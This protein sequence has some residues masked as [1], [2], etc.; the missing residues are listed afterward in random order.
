MTRIRFAVVGA[1]AALVAAAGWFGWR[2]WRGRKLAAVVRAS[3]PTIPDL[4]AWPPAY[5][6]LLREATA[7]ARQGL[8]P[9][10]ALGEI[11]RLYHANGC[12]RQAERAERGLHTIDPDN[13]KWTYLLADTCDMRG[14]AS[15]ERQY[16]VAALQAAPYY[17]PIRLRIANL[18]FNQGDDTDAAIHY[19]WLLTMV[20][21]DPAAHLGL[22]RIALQNGNRRRAI[23]E[24]NAITRDHPTY[25]AAHNLL[26]DIYATAGDKARAAEQRRLSGSSGEFLGTDDPWL[27]RVYAWSFDPD[28]QAFEGSPETRVQLM[29]AALPFYR[30]AASAAPHSGL[31]LAAVGSLYLQIGRLTEARTALEAGLK[32]DP[33]MPELYL[34][35]A[36]VLRKQD[37]AAD[38]INVLRR[39]IRAL[40]NRPDLRRGLDAV[41][42]GTT[43]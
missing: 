15:T 20:P 35:L 38:A 37:R 23:A 7:A 11:A 43:S 12:Y 9:V 2:E 28:R 5:A 1:L 10:T 13:V 6:V 22:A 21:G 25:A 26:A 31:A 30:C 19:Q 32:S 27:T 14:D 36:E 39:G 29:A 42:K 17:A 41:R 16:L 40:P 34:L 33:R 4:T 8:Q 24:L 3:V 18:L